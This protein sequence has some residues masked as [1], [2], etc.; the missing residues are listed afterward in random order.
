M[1]P[2]VLARAHW[3]RANIKSISTR[4]RRSRYFQEGGPGIRTSWGAS[5]VNTGDGFVGSSGVTGVVGVA[6]VAEGAGAG[7]DVVDGAGS[8]DDAGADSVDG[9]GS[10]EGAGAGDLDA[11]DGAGAGAAAEDLEY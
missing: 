5:E 6:G 11:V 8:A 10:A 4:E 7:A 3:E 1:K 9:A 2:Q